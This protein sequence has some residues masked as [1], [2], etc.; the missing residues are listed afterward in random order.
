SEIEFAAKYTDATIIGI[1]G[2]N[3]KTTTTKWTY[4]ILKNAGLSVGMA[5]NVGDSF[6][7]QVA[8][9]HVDFYVL[10]LSSFQLDGIIDFKP[11]ISVIVNIT[12]DH[13]DRYNYNLEEYVASKFRITKNQTEED[14]FIYDGDDELINTWFKDHPVR[15]KELPFSV[16]RKVENGAYLE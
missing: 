6:A 2:S 7:L 14:F 8:E 1:T 9:T 13:L 11:H 10:E 3:G 4:H 16:S 12:P 5:G 15:A